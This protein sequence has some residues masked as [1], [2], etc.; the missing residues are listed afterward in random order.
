M[1]HCRHSIR[2]RNYDYKSQGLYFITICTKDREIYFDRNDIREMIDNIWLELKNKYPNID[3]DEYVVMPNHI[4]GI[5]IINDSERD[6][7]GNHKSYPYTERPRLGDII[8]SFKSVATHHYIKNIELKNW[9]KFNQKLFQRNYYEHIIRN[10]ESL[11]KIRE[12]I[13]FNPLNWDRDRNNP[14]N[15]KKEL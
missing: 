15:F 7:E 9:P 14:K 6:G 13:K 8:G 10:E 4:H 5:I 12:Y 3:L 1:E 11:N 2:L